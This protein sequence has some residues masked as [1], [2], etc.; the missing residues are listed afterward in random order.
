MWVAGDVVE[1]AGVRHVI[2]RG[3]GEAEC[4]VVPALDQA[5]LEPGEH[6]R[7]QAG[8]AVDRVDVGELVVA[9]DKGEADLVADGKV[10]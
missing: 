6:R 7:G 10:A 1:G 9:A 5:S 2:E 8:S 4:D 3:V